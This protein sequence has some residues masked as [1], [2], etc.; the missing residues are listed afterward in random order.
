VENKAKAVYRRTGGGFW[1]LESA[2]AW[3]LSMTNLGSFGEPP[4]QTAGYV[5]PI[6]AVSPTTV[7]MVL[8][9]VGVVYTTDGTTWTPLDGT[10]PG[11]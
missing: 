8:D 3:G 9:D 10:P 11:S 6:Q 4:S 5:G 7:Y 2:A 1:L